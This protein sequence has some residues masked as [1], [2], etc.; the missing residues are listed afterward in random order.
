MILV[1][2]SVWIDYLAGRISAQTDLLDE[3][4][5]KVE[6]A[7]GDLILMEIL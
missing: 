3:V 5:G 2:T 7:M 6:V 1:D 4:M